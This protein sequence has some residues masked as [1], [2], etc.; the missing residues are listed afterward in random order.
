MKYFIIGIG[1]G[2]GAVVRVSLAQLFPVILHNIPFSIIIVNAIGCF[3][4]GLVS[5]WVISNVHSEIARQF[6]FPGFLGGFTTFSAFAMDFG[7]LC[8]RQQYDNAIIYVVLSIIIPLG[9]FL[10][11]AKFIRI[12][13]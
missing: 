3:V 11:G 13:S 6:L 9:C 12:I 5:F 7:Q 2:L 8:D 1:G 4:A 10:L